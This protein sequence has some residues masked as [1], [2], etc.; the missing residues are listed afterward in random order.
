MKK[1]KEPTHGLKHNH[2]E[3]V[4]SVRNVLKQAKNFSEY[5]KMCDTAKER[6]NKENPFK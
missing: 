6:L 5:K 1:P 4:E 3:I 2:D